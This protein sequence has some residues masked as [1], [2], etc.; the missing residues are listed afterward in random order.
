MKVCAHDRAEVLAGAIALGEATDEERIEYRRHVSGC[1]KCLHAFGGEHQLEALH[2]VVRSAGAGEVWEPDV[3]H[4]LSEFRAVAPRRIANYGLALLGLAVVIS[5]IGHVV[6][7]SS[8]AHPWSDP[9]VLDIKADRVV[10]ERRS[11]RDAPAPTLAAVVVVEHHIVQ[12]RPVAHAL[13]PRR[14]AV[15]KNTQSAPKGPDPGIVPA[16]VSMNAST[17]AARQMDAGSGV[18]SQSNEPPWRSAIPAPRAAFV[19]APVPA[20]P[21]RSEMLTIAPVY[22]MREAQPEHGDF[23]INPNPPA[24]AAQ[25][26]AEGTTA[27]EVTI[28]ENGNPTKCVV[29]MSS[30]YLVLDEATCRAAMK[31]HYR[32]KTVNGKPVPG[33]YRDAFTYRPPNAYAP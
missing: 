30:S 28:D 9:P 17:P 16:M 23:S 18:A 11:T 2:H 13:A 4:S 12:L 29:A 31:I 15:L 7:G 27:F 33:V 1:P 21:A 20:G 32:P 25:E 22:S 19:N 26:G 8:F 3:W 24:I 6:V 5:L 14:A 10:L